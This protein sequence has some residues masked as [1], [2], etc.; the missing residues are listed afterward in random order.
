MSAIGKSSAGLDGVFGC[1]VC[2]GAGM[3]MLGVCACCAAAAVG[4]DAS[5]SPLAATARFIF[6]IDLRWKRGA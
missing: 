2:G 4:S 1:S 6:T 3:F 5:A